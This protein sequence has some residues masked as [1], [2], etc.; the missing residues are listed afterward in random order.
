MGM[1]GAPEVTVARPRA[2]ERIESPLAP[3]PLCFA[4][5]AGGFDPAAHAHDH[6]LKLP[7][8]WSEIFRRLF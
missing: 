2:T 6:I 1:S 8:G 3:K 5:Q 4:W 7:L